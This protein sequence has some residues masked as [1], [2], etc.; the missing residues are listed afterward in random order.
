MAGQEAINIMSRFNFE[1]SAKVDADGASGGLLAMWNNELTIQTITQSPQ[2]LY[3][4]QP[5]I[6]TVVYSKPYA[7]SKSSLWDNLKKFCLNNNH[8]HLVLGDFNDITCHAENFGGLQPSANRMRKFRDNIEACNL[9][10]LG[11][12]GPRFTWSNLRCDAVITIS[13]WNG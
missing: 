1:N 5:F 7:S 11:F 6:I 2:E 13:L 9:I 3:H 12:S 4:S 10:D 8:P